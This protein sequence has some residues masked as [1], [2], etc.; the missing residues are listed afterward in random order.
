LVATLASKVAGAVRA[1][2]ANDSLRITLVGDAL[3][4]DA[5]LGTELRHQIDRR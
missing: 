1:A 2:R 3:R 4:L 5:L